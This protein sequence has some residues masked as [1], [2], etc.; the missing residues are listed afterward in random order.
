MC[1]S[2]LTDLHQVAMLVKWRKRTSVKV[3]L[4]YTLNIVQVYFNILQVYFNLLNYRRKSILQ[5]Y[6]ISI[7]KVGAHFLIKSVF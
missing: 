4:N 1:L 5:V 6:V 3:Y 2:P 7:K